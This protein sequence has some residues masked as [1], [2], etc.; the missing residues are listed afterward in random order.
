MVVCRVTEIATLLHIVTRTADEFRVLAGTC[1]CRQK[2]DT[3]S[4]QYCAL[5]DEAVKELCV[6]GRMVEKSCE[7]LDATRDYDTAGKS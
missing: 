1:A 4:S 6:T 2:I 3:T 7:I 5:L